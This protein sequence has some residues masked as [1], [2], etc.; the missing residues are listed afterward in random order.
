MNSKEILEEALKLKPDERFSVIEGILSSLDTPDE[1][2]DSIW[3]DEA[4]RRLKAHRDGKLEGVP[5]EEVFR[6]EK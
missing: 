2:L 6:E 4:Q 5:M 1:K 3:A